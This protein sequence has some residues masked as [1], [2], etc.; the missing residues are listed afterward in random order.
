MSPLASKDHPLP[1]PRHS[2]I[3]HTKILSNQPKVFLKGGLSLSFRTRWSQWTRS[4]NIFISSYFSFLNAQKIQK[5]PKLDIRC[6]QKCFWKGGYLYVSEHAD[7]NELGVKIYF[8]LHIF[9]F[10]MSQKSTNVQNWTFGATKSVFER[11][12]IF[13]IQNTLIPMN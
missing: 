6:H 3:C 13:T 9:H 10:W 5:C 11:G 2:L 1:H 12:V 8:F 4:Q 7:S